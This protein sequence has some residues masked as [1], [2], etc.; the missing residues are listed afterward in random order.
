MHALSSFKQNTYLQNMKKGM[1]HRRM[2]AFKTVW[3]P[4]RYS[5][6]IRLNETHILP[7]GQLVI[8]IL[9]ASKGQVCPFRYENPFDTRL[10]YRKPHSRSKCGFHNYCAHYVSACT[11]A[12]WFCTF[13][14]PLFVYEAFF[15][16]Y[17]TNRQ[18]T[19]LTKP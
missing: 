8:E 19:D 17:K 5:P 9:F 7:R 2:F 16:F 6:L 3:A 11:R 13:K 12:P 14:L 10:S 15:L 18:R 4:R 1:Y